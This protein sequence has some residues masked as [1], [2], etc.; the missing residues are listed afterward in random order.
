M[1][2]KAKLTGSLIVPGDKS[3]SHRALIFSALSRGQSKIYGLSPAEDCQSSASCLKHL[4]LSI[5]NEDDGKVMATRVISPGLAGLIAPREL[6][7]AGNSGTTIRLLSGLVAG[8]NFAS[9]FDG[10]DSLRGRPMS[11]VLKPLSQMGAQISYDK[12]QGRPPF[13]ISGHELAGQVFQLEVASAQVET[14]LLLAGLQ[15]MGQTTVRLPHIARDHTARMFRFLG[16]PFTQSADGAMTV[17]KI[18]EPVPPF[19]LFVPGDISSAAFFMVAAACLPGSNVVLE[20]IGMNPGRT[21]VLDVLR[22]LGADISLEKEQQLCGE[23]VADIRVRGGNKLKGAS[24]SADQVAQGVDE[25]P[26]L[27]L[28]GCMCE[29]DFSVRGAAELRHKESDRLALIVENI[30]A[31]GGNIEDYEDGFVIHGSG[32]LKGASHWSTKLDHRLAM[33]GLVA[34]LLCQSPVTVEETSSA[35]ISYPSFARDLNKLIA[36]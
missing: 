5:D 34:Q 23:P 12:E 11:R 13:T 6:L 7:F 16:V 10:D 17:S 3:I 27:A 9:R 28:A 32:S 35:A 20:R 14:A 31:A 33:S 22:D 29:G 30:R 25:I 18:V 2:R 36:D 1:S 19:E 8:R 26:I 24:I 15:A 4:G 21:L